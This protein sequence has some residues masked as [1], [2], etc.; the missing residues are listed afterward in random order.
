V[1]L[2]RNTFERVHEI[3]VPKSHVV[4]TLWHPKLN[5]IIIGAGDGN[6]HLYYDVA[7]SHNGAKLCLGKPKKIRQVKIFFFL[8][9]SV[10]FLNFYGLKH[11]VMSTVRVITPHALP[12]FREDKPRSTRRAM[13]KARKDPLLSKQPD[14]PIGNK[15]KLRFH[16]V[17]PLSILKLLFDYLFRFRWSSCD[18]R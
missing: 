16:H 17:S 13:E 5:Q 11:D 18:F 3:D 1:F 6:I 4:R 15:G 8:S 2:D 12:M 9:E 10:D 14:L 7:K